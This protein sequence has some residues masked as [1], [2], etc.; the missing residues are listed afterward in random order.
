MRVLDLWYLCRDWDNYKS[1]LQI[2][3]LHVFQSK[4][5]GAYC[6]I[7]IDFNKNLIICFKG[8]ELK[9]NDILSDLLFKKMVI[10][11]NN[12]TNKK[13]KVHSGFLLQYLSLRK[14]IHNFLLSFQDYGNIYITG[15]SLGAALATL[16]ILD[17]EYNF[18]L[19]AL[20][21]CKI[22]GTPRIGN[23]Y[24]KKSF[25]NR[26]FSFKH[27]FLSYQNVNDIITKLPLKI[28]GFKH[29]DKIIK[30]GKLRWWFPF[31]IKQHLNYNE[32]LTD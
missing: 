28:M 12:M 31:S 24:F 22:F 1:K 7:G 4:I 29:V 23:K 18:N 8:T 2:I 26:M 25:E 5:T 21:T 13:I 14:E 20:I 19:S 30:I 16:C 17:I 15:H 27:F 3:D 32:W 9:L 10:P 6:N 11:Y